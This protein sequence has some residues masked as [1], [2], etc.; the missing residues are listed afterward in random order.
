[1]RQAKKIIAETF[2]VDVDKLTDTDGPDSIERWDSL[3][4]MNLVASIEKEIGISLEIDE[5]MEL[6]NIAA[7][8]RLL[9]AKG[10]ESE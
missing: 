3:G 2:D 8:S 10:A 4:H 1:M 7:V 5:I 9:E 6:H